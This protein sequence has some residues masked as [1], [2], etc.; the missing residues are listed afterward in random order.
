MAANNQGIYHLNLGG[1]VACKNQ[2]AHMFI[3]LD[4]FRAPGLRCKRCVAVVTKMDASAAKRAARVAAA[5]PAPSKYSLEYAM[6][7][8]PD[9]FKAQS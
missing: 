3:K 6:Q 8:W 7:Q 5:A 1:R 9:N 4:E 2:S